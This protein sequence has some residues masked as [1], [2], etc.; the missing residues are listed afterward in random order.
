MTRTA[1]RQRVRVIVT[2]DPELDDLNSMLRLVLYSNEIEL[3]GL[4]RSSSVLH[5]AGD[6]ALGIEPYRWPPPGARSHIDQALDAYEQVYEN[7]QVHDP[8]YPA[9][10]ALRSLV[11]EGNVID[12]GDRREPSAGS[13]LIADVLLDDEQGIVVV[14]A[15]GG[16]NT[17]ARALMTIEERHAGR[18]E[19]PAIHARV[20]ART[21]LTSW[22]E[23]DDAFAAYIRPNWSEMEMRQVATMVWG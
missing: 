20:T 23:Q 14:Q 13:D 9:P 11:R 2:T 16:F 19:W 12:G 21:V 17:I 4:I 15:W 6:V 1:E 3:A 10:T 8:R 5:Y 18:A 7:L 22:G